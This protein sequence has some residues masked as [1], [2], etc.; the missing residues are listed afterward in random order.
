MLLWYL[1]LFLSILAEN[2]KIAIER[3]FGYLRVVLVMPKAL[4][5]TLLACLLM[6]DILVQSSAVQSGE[7]IMHYGQSIDDVGNSQ[8]QIPRLLGL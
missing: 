2:Y 1:K 3:G 8:A 5:S 4:P 7:P 6:F